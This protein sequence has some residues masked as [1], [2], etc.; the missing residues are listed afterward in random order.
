LEIFEFSNPNGQANNPL[1][2]QAARARL[3]NS[4]QAHEDFLKAAG[5]FEP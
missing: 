2:G 3:N 1:P 4:R 5:M